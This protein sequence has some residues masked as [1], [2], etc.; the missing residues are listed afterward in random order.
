MI[1]PILVMSALFLSMSANALSVTTCEEAGVTLNAV[2]EMKGY[3]NGRIKLFAADM[4]EPA[5]APV[6]LAV[7]IDRGDDLSTMESYCRYVSGLSSLQLSKAQASYD[8]SRN[9]LKLDIPARY[10]DADNGKYAHTVLNVVVSPGAK[11]QAGL[12]EAKLK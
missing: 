12:V 4:I 7:T 2:T 10:F 1:R 9:I 8:R 6:G 3:G 11:D 5:A